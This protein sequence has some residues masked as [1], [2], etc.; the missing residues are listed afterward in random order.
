MSSIGFALI[1]K[2]AAETLQL[3]ERPREP[4]AS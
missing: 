4:N 3:V 1:A 2:N